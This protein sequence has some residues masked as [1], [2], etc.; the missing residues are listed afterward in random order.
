[1]ANENQKNCLVILGMHRSGTSALSGVL[2]ILGMSLG[3]QMMRSNEY[4]P[5]GYFENQPIVDLN[6]RIMDRLGFAWDDPF[7]FPENWQQQDFLA[8]YQHQ[9]VEILESEFTTDQLIG[10]KDP[11]I[12]I[13]LPW[14]QQTLE[15]CNLTP[16]YPII[17]RHPLEV[18]ASLAKRD[19]F[20][21]QKSVLLW[22]KHMLEAEFHTRNQP[23]CFL[24]FE[25]LL[26]QPVESLS[27][28]ASALQFSFPYPLEERKQEILRF[29]EKD[30]KHHTLTEDATPCLPLA[31]DYYHL[32]QK[33]SE[34]A[35]HDSS[36]MFQ[37]I[38]DLRTQYE[39]LRTWF[40]PKELHG[41]ALIVKHLQAEINSKQ[42]EI[43]Q[44]NPHYHAQLFVD[45]GIGFNEIQTIAMPVQGQE[46][47]IVFD[48]SSY[49][50]IKTLRFDPLNDLTVLHLNSV[51]L[52]TA[53]GDAIFIDSYQTNACFQNG[54][55]LL[56]DTPDPNILFSAPVEQAQKLVISL[57]YIAL[58]QSAYPHLLSHKA[59]QLSQQAAELTQK[60]QQL[61]QKEAELYRLTPHY[62]AQLFLDTG[63]GFNETQTIAIPV[64]GQ[65]REIEFD[66][67]AYRDIKTLRFD[68]LNDLTVLHLNS[69]QFM[70]ADGSVL[71]VD[72]YQTNA[73]FQKGSNLLFD[74]PDPNIT[75]A[76]PVEQAQKVVISLEYIAL[77][78]V[79]YPY[80]LQEKNRQFIEQAQALQAKD[81][82][83]AQQA[84]VLQSKDAEL[85]QQSRA[86]QE[87]DQAI[88]QHNEL[89][90]RYEEKLSREIRSR[91][92]LIQVQDDMIQR[93]ENTLSWRITKPLRW[94]S[95]F[96][97]L[98]RQWPSHDVSWKGKISR[99]CAKTLWPKRLILQSGL[100]DQEYYLAHNPDV[101]QTGVN[102]LRHF[103]RHGGCEGRQPCAEFDAAYYLENNPDV[104]RK[105]LNPLIHYLLYGE[106]D[107]RRPSRS[108]DPIY[109]RDHNPDVASQNVNLLSHYVC[110]GQYEG[111][112]P[113]RE[114]Q[115]IRESDFF[116][117]SCYLF[118]NPDVAQ[119]GINPLEHFLW[120]GGFEGRQP[121]RQF[122]SQFY[123][124]TY[125]DVAQTQINP[126]VHYLL[127]GKQEG[128]FPNQE[129]QLISESGLFDNAYYLAQNQDVAQVGIDPVEHFLWYGGFEG[130]NPHPLFDSAYYLRIYPDVKQS[131]IN[132]LVHYLLHGGREGR[133]PH[134]DFNPFDY[135]NMN[136]DVK[137]SGMDPLVHYCRHGKKEGRQFQVDV[138]SFSQEVKP[139]QFDYTINLSMTM[140]RLR[141]FLAGSDRMVFP[142]WESPLVS[143]ILLQWNKGEFTYQCLESL[144]ICTDVSYEIVLVDNGSTGEAAA[145]LERLENVTIIKNSENL[146]F[147]R[148]C[149]Q[150]VQ[151]AR[152]KYVLFLN[153]DTQVLPNT[154]AAL[155]NTIEADFSVGAVGGKLI[156]PNGTLQE[157][158]SAIWNDASC[159]T[160]GRGEDPFKPEFSYL[161]EVYYCAGAL[162]L[163]PRQLFMDLG[164]FDEL[165]LPA[166]YEDVDYCM[167]VR[168]NRYKVIYQPLAQVIHYEFATTGEAPSIRF[169]LMNRPKFQKRWAHEL[170][171]YYEP[172]QE[173]I[174]FGREF[175]LN[176]SKKRI[177]YIDDMIPD[178]QLGSG[179]PRS[180]DMLNVLIESGYQVSLFPLQF[181]RKPELITQYFQQK[182]VEV[183]YDYTGKER[184]LSLETFLENRK[185]YYDIILISRPHNMKEFL[186]IRQ[187]LVDKNVQIIYDAEAV[188]AGREILYRE[189]VGET[190]TEEEKNRF[191]QEEVELANQ[192]DA[193]VSVSKHEKEIFESY[194]IKNIHIVG[195]TRT[196][197]PTPATFEERRDFLCIGSVLASPCPNEDAILYFVT[198]I[199]PAVYERTRAKLFIVG[200]NKSEA[201]NCLPESHPNIIVT[202]RVE[203]LEEYY[204]R[205][206][207]FIIS[208]RY[209]AGLPYKFHEAAS[210]GIPAVVTPLIAEQIGEQEGKAFL[211]GNNEEDFAQ[212]CVELYTNKN[213]W[214]KMR[215][216]TLELVEKDCDP[217]IFKKHFLK[218]L[219]IPKKCGKGLE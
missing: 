145:L 143:I 132:P 146:G 171:H 42:A 144:Q 80:L 95:N 137:A 43:R 174:L 9:F 160:Y 98:Q 89:I 19:R 14:W 21:V 168:D 33:L 198:Q 182:G 206:R 60:D 81:T 212:K 91:T 45:T 12:C 141:A 180:F 135:L 18:A 125:P 136:L 96:K 17:V 194:G 131:G 203:R 56:F 46:R 10:F 166:T 134:P 99:F 8:V 4:N 165:Y 35:D 23:R 186:A 126:L 195:H 85:A 36:A 116:D 106:R 65:E 140:L 69:V 128:R 161:K 193:V 29:L 62:A 57:E 94:L 205:C 107:N 209:A 215:Q 120:Q 55:N 200:T 153:N 76:A 82:E 154:L 199:Y 177:L 13:L 192:A 61:N 150:G 108:F 15:K 86:L 184:K 92:Q 41:T 118:Q 214:E 210:Y 109:Y 70:T 219:D 183:F 73:C 201:I 27:R 167:K 176:S 158:G 190:F 189:L 78:P 175:T 2:N 115:V 44:L 204:N 67:S 163:T 11:R 51:Q 72:D 53:E 130:R 162:L 149:N 117:E 208:T 22:M 79:A 7:P 104:L 25:Q 207:V 66:L 164:M 179:Y 152:G 74:T 59:Q 172:V 187:D 38:D 123:L 101:A 84:Q 32:L 52:M 26:R 49:H 93:M 185:S 97:L 47:E 216:G 28:L 111:R 64:Q 77:G 88:Q 105:R 169:Q 63:L 147:L 68:P 202:G 58:G 170:A 6:D 103:V 112:F 119:T 34:C 102:P 100:F 173:N 142:Q 218:V 75:F 113:N 197:Q 156:F 48:L 90:R 5:K 124:A 129:T 213:L 148:A 54:N 157:A 188:F 71:P 20:S 50:D 151:Y 30:L 3:Q 181:G 191:I 24:S 1:M 127:Y 159:S 110:Y 40:C 211:I 133:R 121:C 31:I 139:T 39:N 37:K 178:P 196:I 83:L 114:T 217:Q 16:Y 122:D 138:L 87:R 155:V